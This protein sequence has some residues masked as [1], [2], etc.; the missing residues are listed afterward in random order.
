MHHLEEVW[1]RF[2]LQCTY[3]TVVS[4]IDPRVNQIHLVP[5]DGESCVDFSLLHILLTG[6]CHPA[7]SISQK[8]QKKD[9]LHW[10]ISE[11]LMPLY[12]TS[13]SYAGN[14]RA[15]PLS[16]PPSVERESRKLSMMVYTTQVVWGATV[17]HSRL[18]CFTHLGCS[19]R[20]ETCSI[21]RLGSQICLSMSMGVVPKISTLR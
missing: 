8:P 13:F 3:S 14:S 6:D 4:H 16:R 12:S 21:E 2:H 9:Q 10:P 5:V 18:L 1:A 17:S 20:A 19:E 15:T 7:A 11:T